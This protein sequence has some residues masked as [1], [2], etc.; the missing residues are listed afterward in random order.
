MSHR[1]GPPKPKLKIYLKQK[2]RVNNIND[3]NDDYY[4]LFNRARYCGMHPRYD[5]M[6][7]RVT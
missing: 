3:N 5:W 4:Y 7:M 6:E 2:G 1:G